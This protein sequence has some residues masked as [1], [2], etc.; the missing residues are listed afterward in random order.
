[1]DSSVN[2]APF[3]SV[4]VTVMG[5]SRS[6]NGRPISDL[7]LLISHMLSEYNRGQGDRLQAV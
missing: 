3:K 5:Q 4:L 6:W 7:V 2:V 1:M